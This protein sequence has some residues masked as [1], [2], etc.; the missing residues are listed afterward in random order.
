VDGGSYARS[1][2][3]IPAFESLQTSAGITGAPSQLIN[4]EV[5]HTAFFLA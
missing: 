1:R 2:K 5:Q 3:V 4:I